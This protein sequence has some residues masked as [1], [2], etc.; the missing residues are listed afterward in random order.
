MTDKDLI[1]KLNTL[2]NINP[3]SSW[4]TS[5]RDILLSQISNSGA[6]KLST[7]RVFSINFNSV[8]AAVSKPAYALGAFI[9]ILITGSLFSHQVFGGAKPNDSLYIA[10]II[11]EK[12]KL[13]TMFNSD[14]RN[15]LAVQF[16][17]EHAQ[18][19][20]T[21]LANPEF[22]ND[23][24]KDQIAKLNDSFNEE[25]NTVKSR[26]S[27]LSPKKI[28]DTPL[29]L[30]ASGTDIVSIADSG[31]DNKGLQ[32]LEAPN[33]KVATLSTVLLATVTPTAT[34][35]TST[36]ATADTMLDEAKQLFDKKDYTKAADKLKE[37]DDMIK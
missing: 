33:A 2:K 17:T 9:L 24:N 34:I 30:K 13:N 10:R 27:Y 19:I 21:I 7:W 15:K 18:D 37:V 6:L 31:K 3:D 16:A 32:L 14:E 12:A 20:S 36:D 26:I 11:S 5:N 25:I 1:K 29:E 22:N 23:S 28:S 8:V 35:A 4:K